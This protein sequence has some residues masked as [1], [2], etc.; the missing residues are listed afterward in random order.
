MAENAINDLNQAAQ[1][2]RGMLDDP[3]ATPVEEPKKEP[4]QEAQET[5][6]VENEIVEE[7]QDEP[8][9]EAQAS[10]TVEEESDTENATETGA[11]DGAEAIELGAEDLSEVLN[12]DLDRINITDDGQLRFKVKGAE[13]EEDV[14]LEKLVN[15]YQGDANLTNRSKQLSEI[16][17]QKTEA[18][19]S[20]KSQTT[21]QAQKAAITLEAINNQFMAEYQGIDWNSLKAEEP[22]EYAAKTVEM[23]QKK[24]QIDNL[25]NQ[26]LEQIQEQQAAIEAEET[27]AR[28]ERLAEEERKTAEVFKQLGVKTDETLD[29]AMTEYLSSQFDQSELPHLLDHRILKMAYMAMQFE[30]GLTK[31]KDKEVKKKPRVLRP[32]KKPSAQAVKVN[33]AKKQRAKL[34]ETG[35]VEDAA[36]LIKG[37][38]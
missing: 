16:E 15:A 4:T 1:A 8:T 25:V 5:E 3:H 20:F 24:A 14:S 10:E 30:K 38:L 26:T 6:Q 19:E 29:K 21:E 12:L 31:A 37:L 17:K 27:K 33:Q 7:S 28:Q 9:E 32:G 23:Q 35:R 2:M 13:G 36:S 18:L 11:D 22:G 34:K